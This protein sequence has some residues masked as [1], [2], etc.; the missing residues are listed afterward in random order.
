MNLLEK[1]ARALYKSKNRE[2]K[3]PKETRTYTINF[4]KIN[5]KQRYL[6]SRE[7]KKLFKRYKLEY[8]RLKGRGFSDYDISR[9]LGISEQSIRILS[10]SNIVC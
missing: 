5:A 2:T 4:N 10:R 3:T 7:N 6:K 8:E 9:M 1:L